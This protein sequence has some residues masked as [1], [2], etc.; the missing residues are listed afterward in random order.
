MFIVQVD[1]C[2]VKLQQDNI[3]LPVEITIIINIPDPKEVLENPQ[4]NLEEFGSPS[5]DLVDSQKS[6]SR[7]K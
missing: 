2:V 3:A 1:G 6:K 4:R 7:T 5:S